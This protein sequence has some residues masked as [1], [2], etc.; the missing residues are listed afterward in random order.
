MANFRLYQYYTKLYYF[1]KKHPRFLHCSIS[2]ND[3]RAKISSIE[4]WFKSAECLKYPQSSPLSVGFWNL[5]PVGFHTFDTILDVDVQVE[6]DG[7][8][9]YL[10][11][12][13]IDRLSD[14]MEVINL[15]QEQLDNL[16]K[17]KQAARR[18]L[19]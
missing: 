14:E 19:Q 15:S 11:D 12:D 10:S 16:E 18:L 7:F 13:S 1:L 17:A 6:N 4:K 5:M 8:S 2:F 3:L 9:D